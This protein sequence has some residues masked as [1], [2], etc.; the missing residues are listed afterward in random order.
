[1]SASMNAA[2]VAATLASTVRTAS[3]NSSLWRAPLPN[4]SWKALVR[5]HT[6]RK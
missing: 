3:A 6:N 2:M 5:S 4:S 1:M